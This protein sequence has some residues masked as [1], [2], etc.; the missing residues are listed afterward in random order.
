MTSENHR[1]GLIVLSLLALVAAC[2]GQGTEVERRIAELEARQNQQI[3][4]LKENY[5]ARIAG[6]ETEIRGLKGQVVDLGSDLRQDLER[7]LQELANSG[8]AGDAL[9]QT[10]IFSNVR[11]PALGVVGEFI[12]SGSSLDDD[13]SLYERFALRGVEITI[14]GEVDDA[15]EYYVALHID[16]DE[17]LELEEAFA[18]ARN[19]LPDTFSLKFGRFNVDH[20]KTSPLHE[21]ELPIVDK[22]GV[23]QDYLGGS[24]RGTGVELHHWLPLGDDLL[25]WSLGVFNTADSDAHVIGGPLAGEHHH[26]EDED[27]LPGER[28]LENFAFNARITAI[29]E[30]TP[31]STLQ[32]GGSLL[33][34]PEQR[35]VLEHDHEDEDE[36]DEEP[37][38]RD[39]E[40]LTLSFDL[41]Y[42][43][44]DPSD[45]SGFEALAEFLFNSQET[46][47]PETG[48]V[49]RHHAF[50]FHVVGEYHLDQWLSLGAAF[51][52]YERALEPGESW[53]VGAFVTWKWNEFNRLRLEGR[54]YEDTTFGEDYVLVLV[55]WTT[56][57]GNH[58]HPLP[59]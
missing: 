42:R 40:K 47:D 24:L 23:I 22:P 48:E 45:G 5:E 4:E 37:I 36:D 32:V 54:W 33:W 7:E 30:L 16:E 52:W 12:W 53:D 26:H 56:T 6:L 31:D 3:A 50:G 39:L 19:L 38:I 34:A 51:D 2:R 58:G 20:G 35:G 41:T 57:I 25:R 15:L 43:N 9:G 28:G 8:P 29:F 59:W 27:L 13:F 11:N 46:G 18:L 21:H 17:G 1:T 14:A 10:T 55:Q 49:D 44:I